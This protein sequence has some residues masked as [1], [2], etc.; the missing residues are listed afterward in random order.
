M[1]PASE[2]HANVDALAAALSSLCLVHCLLW[3][4]LLLALPALALA[5]HAGFLAGAAFHWALLATAL[6]VSGWALYAG[7]GRHRDL[8]PAALAVLGFAIMAAGALAHG[9]ELLEAVLTVAG[10]LLVASAHWRNWR[11]AHPG[12]L[13][14]A[15]DQP[16]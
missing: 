15:D 12:A 6:P 13:P 14:G 5:V 10:G 7:L 9:H 2:S 1:K 8:A 3:P 16:A 4:L 11:L